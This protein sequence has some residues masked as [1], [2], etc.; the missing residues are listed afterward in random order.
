[1]TVDRALQRASTRPL[2]REDTYAGSTVERMRIR[3]VASMLRRLTLPSSILMYH[4][5]SRGAKAESF[6]PHLGLQVDVGSFEEQM[7][8]L[9]LTHRCFRLSTFTALSRANKLPPSSA[10]VTFDDGYRDGL[11]L[12]LPILERYHIPATIFVTTG[13]LDGRARLWW[14]ELEAII[15]AS[16][17]LKF[18]WDGKDFHY[19]LTTL[20][21]K[22][23]CFEELTDIFQHLGPTDINKLLNILEHSTGC[24]LQST[25]QMLSWSEVEEL[26]KHPLITLG[27]H[28][29]HHSALR[30][31]TSEVVRE[32]L[33]QS[34]EE[35]SQRVGR[36]VSHFAYPFG[37]HQQVSPR[38]MNIVKELGFSSA[39]ITYFGHVFR[40]YSSYQHA[41]PRIN[42]DWNDTLGTFA[43]KLTG[44]DA[45]I[46]SA[47]K[48]NPYPYQLSPCRE[49]PN[50]LNYMFHKAIYR[51][52]TEHP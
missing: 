24:H 47:I 32:E 34:R 38:E 5:I 14:R 25:V 28:T 8:L 27:A 36:K 11:T 41:L 39:C 23:T 45:L 21:L 35:L 43:R 9:H 46:Y 17:M 16:D 51:H 12:A 37:G 40:K 2:E 52:L 50:S 48:R 15:R 10:A 29:V 22:E 19:P 1:M 26:A 33:Y 42:V 31:Q 13:F 20:Q 30:Y 18:S 4:Q 6:H 7:K 44:I 49:R 3:G